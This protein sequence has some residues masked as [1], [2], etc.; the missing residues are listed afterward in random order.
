MIK[1]FHISQ[2]FGQKVDIYAL[3]S[4]VVIY[5]EKGK[6]EK[7]IRTSMAAPLI[8]AIAASMKAVAK[9]LTPEN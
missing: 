2:T 5:I 3:G 7:I 1:Q 8:A 6:T 9:C 4:D